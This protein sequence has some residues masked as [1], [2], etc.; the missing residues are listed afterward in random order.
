MPIM[1]VE[2][3]DVEGLRR[4]DRVCFENIFNRYSPDLYVVAYRITGNKAV[5]ED[6]VQDFF[7]KLWLN[8]EKVLIYKSFRYYCFSAIH[9]A[10]LNA[11][12]TKYRDAEL[13][14]ELE[15][16]SCVEYEME[17]AE[18]SEKIH[19][20]IDSLPEKCKAIFVDACIEECSYV[21]VAQKYDLSVNT[22]KVQVSKAYR[23]L[24]EKLTKEQF[25]IFLLI[26]LKSE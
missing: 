4:G 1:M 26:F 8:R 19:L 11:A 10:S 5:A 20:A 12:R 15:D 14:E 3:K 2:D 22:V 18:L 25:S 16:P 7:V 17:R 21:E 24:R 13:S 23:I 6:V 9:Y